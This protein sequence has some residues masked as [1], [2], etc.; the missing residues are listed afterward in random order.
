[1][2]FFVC[3]RLY[4]RDRPTASSFVWTSGK[5]HKKIKEHWELSKTPMSN[6]LTGLGYCCEE[7]TVYERGTKIGEGSFGNVYQAKN[8]WT[9]QTVALKEIKR[10]DDRTVAYLQREVE[11]LKKLK[12]KHIVELID[13]CGINSAGKKSHSLAFELCKCDITKFHPAGKAFR[14]SQRKSILQQ[15]L[16]GVAFIH[17]NGYIHRDL[18]PENLL[19]VGKGCIKIAD[20]G[21]AREYTEPVLWEPKEMTPNM[22]TRRY[23]APEILLGSRLYGPPADMWS[24]GCIMGQLLKRMPLFPGKT[25]QELLRLIIA[26]CGSITPNVWPDVVRITMYHLIELPQGRPNRLHKNF[27]Q[28]CDDYLAIDLMSR[29]LQLDP[30]KRLDANTA[31]SHPY[32]R[33]DP[34][35]A[36]YE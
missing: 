21:L 17:A 2:T 26:D 18:K 35:P 34:L 8:L 12:H 3:F 22:G 6:M 24:V 27:Q 33:A 30:N 23:R 28:W 25:D 1:M 4:S 9:H 32:F 15:L 7:E 11:M 5:N 13:V 31:G 36:K 20:F 10:N 19:I 29:L 14:L 16:S